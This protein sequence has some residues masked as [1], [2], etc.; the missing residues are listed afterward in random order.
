M[1]LGFP[2]SRALQRIIQT[3]NPNL[4]FIMET[5]IKER[6]TQ[7]I[8]LKCGFDNFQVVDGERSDRDRA[9]SLALLWNGSVNIYISFYSINHICGFVR[10]K[11]DNQ[12]WYF[13]KIYRI[14]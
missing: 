9:M 12:L 6:E 5:R 14:L 13:S 11:K 1:W 3:K 4:V 8:R 7:A 2:C 10:D